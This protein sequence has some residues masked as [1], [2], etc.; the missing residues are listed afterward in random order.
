MIIIFDFNSSCEKAAQICSN[1]GGFAAWTCCRF[2]GW[3]MVA[4]E[5]E[6]FMLFII[7]TTSYYAQCHPR[8]IDF[9][10]LVQLGSMSL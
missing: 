7:K 2:A 10:S 9:C 1:F 4:A 3:K 8:T 6:Q 5:Q